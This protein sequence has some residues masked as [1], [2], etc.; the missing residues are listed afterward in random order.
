MHARP[1]APPT[2]SPLLPPALPPARRQLGDLPLRRHRD[3]PLR[4]HLLD[5]LDRLVRGPAGAGIGVEQMWED[6]LDTAVEFVEVGVLPDVERVLKGRPYR[7]HHFLEAHG[8]VQPV[9]RDPQRRV[10][11]RRLAQGHLCEYRADAPDV[12]GGCRWATILTLR[13]LR[14]ERNLEVALGQRRVAHDGRGPEVA[15]QRPA[16]LEPHARREEVGVDDP[17]CVEVPGAVE[18]VE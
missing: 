15:D 2:R 11:E 13:R 9:L 14:I 18:H 17:R 6:L 10:L 3:A 7:H 4:R 12:V 8:P 1:S 16:L 5:A